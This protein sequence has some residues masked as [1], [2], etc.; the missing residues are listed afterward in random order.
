MYTIG[1]LSTFLSGFISDMEKLDSFSE[2]Y[3]WSKIM[4][5]LG[6]WTARYAMNS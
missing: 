2:S 4:F 3:G 5:K 1:G 6:G